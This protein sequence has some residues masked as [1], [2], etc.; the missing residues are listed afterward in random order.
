MSFT[1]STGY[2]SNY[3]YLLIGEVD[4]DNS[5]NTTLPSSIP[6][7]HWTHWT[8]GTSS[9]DVDSNTYTVTGLSNELHFIDI[10][11][12]KTRAWNGDDDRAYVAFKVET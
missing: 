12:V 3:C 7:E 4:Y 9:D 5:N 8:K 6:G 11:F 2:Y 1:A 10:A